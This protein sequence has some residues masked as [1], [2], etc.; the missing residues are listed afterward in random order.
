MTK[1]I[2]YIATSQD[3]YIADDKGGVDWLPQTTE[4]TGGEDYGYPAF[5]DSVDAIAIGRKTYDQILGFGDWPYPGKTSYIFSRS[6]QASHR[7]DIQFVSENIPDFMRSLAQNKVK[8]LWMVGGSALIE[9]FY[10]KGFIDEFIVTV[11]P[12]MLKS[13]IPFTTLDSALKANALSQEKHIDYGLG[14]FQ[15]HYTVKHTHTL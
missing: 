12:K 1:V 7:P 2:V 10:E 3:G 5:Y 6:P 14:V 4:D 15:V 9:A 13:G 11:F 8:T